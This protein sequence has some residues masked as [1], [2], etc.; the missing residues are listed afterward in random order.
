MALSNSGNLP[1][2]RGLLLLALGLLAAGGCSARDILGLYTGPKPSR[3]DIVG[4]RV[5]VRRVYVTTTG[6]SEIHLDRLRFIEAGDLRNVNRVILGS[7]QEI[8]PAVRTL[9]IKPGDTLRVS[10][11]YL[12]YSVSSSPGDSVPGWAGYDY[13]E[14]YPVA[15]HMLTRVERAN[16]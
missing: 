11:R 15:V 16:R 5:V 3:Q 4:E 13:K 6:I 9:A 1:R 8:Q 12:H 10:S 2:S 14:G 7:A